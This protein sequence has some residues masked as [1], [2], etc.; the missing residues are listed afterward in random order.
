MKCSDDPADRIAHYIADSAAPLIVAQSKIAAQL[1][2]NDA[3]V[4]MVDADHGAD[5]AGL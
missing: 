5:G 4:V 3:K 2:D 1:P